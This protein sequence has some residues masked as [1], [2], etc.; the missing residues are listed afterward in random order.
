MVAAFEV[1]Y[2]LAHAHPVM[3]VVVFVVTLVAAVVDA[4]RNA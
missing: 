2:A 4:R 3:L 1:V